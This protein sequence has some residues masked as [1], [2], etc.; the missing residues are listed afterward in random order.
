[1]LPML[2]KTFKPQMIE[3][4]MMYCVRQREVNSD[5]TQEIFLIE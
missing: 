5:A 2:V 1:M 3:M 4:I